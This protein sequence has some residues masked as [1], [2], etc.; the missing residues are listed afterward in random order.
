MK[1]RASAPRLTAKKASSKLVIPQIFTLTT[2]S[3]LL[4]GIREE[5]KV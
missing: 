2:R 4:A 3:L 1:P 5:S